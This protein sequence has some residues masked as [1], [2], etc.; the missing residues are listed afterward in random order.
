MHIL[1]FH[2]H[3]L[4]DRLW[5]L[6]L[7]AW[8]ARLGKLGRALLECLTVLLEYL[9]LS[10]WSQQAFGRVWALRGPPLAMQL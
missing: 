1:T 4:Y 7:F 10:G 2:V 8:K 5:V 9:N 6:V 3:Y